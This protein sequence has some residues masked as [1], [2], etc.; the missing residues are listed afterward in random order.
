MDIIAAPIIAGRTIHITAVD[1]A[2]IAPITALT[3][4]PITGRITVLTTGPT[5]VGTIIKRPAIWF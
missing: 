1:M 5:T 2:I 3:I 4:V